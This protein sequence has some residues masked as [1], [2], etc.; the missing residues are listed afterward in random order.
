MLSITIFFFNIFLKKLLALFAP[1]ISAFSGTSGRNNAHKVWNLKGDWNYAWDPGLMA[2][3]K[4][5]S[6]S[7]FPLSANIY[8]HRD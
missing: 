8:A 6:R 7:F 3:F 4:R 2:R 1:G 5:L